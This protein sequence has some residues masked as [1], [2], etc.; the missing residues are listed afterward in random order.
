[1][2][3]RRGSEPIIWITDENSVVKENT[4]NYNMVTKTN[5]TNANL[6]T[7]Q[8]HCNY[9]DCEHLCSYTDN[10]ESSEFR[11]S[12][13][14]DLSKVDCSAFLRVGDFNDKTSLSMSDVSKNEIYSEQEKGRWEELNTLLVYTSVGVKARNKVCECNITLVMRCA[15][16]RIN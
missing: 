3:S 12:S 15:C 16:L 11:R 9:E 6:S 2:I 4:T 7:K 5:K 13:T 14:G 1:M 10:M 8:N